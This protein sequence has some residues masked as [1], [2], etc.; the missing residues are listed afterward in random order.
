MWKKKTDPEVEP[1]AD[2]YNKVRRRL[3]KHIEKHK[4]NKNAKQEVEVLE[5][6]EDMIDLAI[7]SERNPAIV[8]TSFM[9]LA[10]ECSDAIEMGE[11]TILNHVKD[12]FEQK[13]KK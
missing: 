4:D 3:K 2:F 10:M 7:L 12:F 1:N 11:E 6:A 5:L 9:T 8:I 13:G